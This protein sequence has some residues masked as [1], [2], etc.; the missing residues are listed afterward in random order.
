MN[1]IRKFQL[2]ATLFWGFQVDIDIL[3]LNSMNDVNIISKNELLKFLKNN[4]LMELY[5]K[6]KNLNIHNHLC[7]NITP[8]NFLE[9]TPEGIVTYLCDYQHNED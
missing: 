9:K 4:N 2:S 8:K 5:D 1:T 6:A 7:D 3:S